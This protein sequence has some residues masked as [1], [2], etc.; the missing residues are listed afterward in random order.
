MNVTSNATAA[1]SF[2]L[3]FGLK[4]SFGFM[5]YAKAPAINLRPKESLLPEMSD[6][7]LALVAPVVA[8]WALSGIFHV[9][10]TFHLAEK[11]RIHP[12]EEVAKRNKASRMHVFLE[13]ILQHI[14][15][16]IVGLIFMHFE[17]IYM[18]G[19]EENAMWKLRADL[20]RIIPDAAIYYGY[21]YGMSALKIFAGFLF[22][23]TWQ[24][25]LHRLMH[26]NK[27]LYKWF[28][29]VHHELYVPY[30]YGA[31][32][33]N[34]VEG[35]LLDTLGTGI[36]M[37]LTHLTHR[38]QIILFTFATMKTVDDHCGYALPLDPFQWLFPNN[39]VYHDIHHQQFGIKTNFAQPFFTFW[40][41]LFQTNVK[42]FEEYQK[43][44]RRVTIDK[45]KEFLQKR[46][47]EKKEKLKNFKAMNAAENEVK[48][49]K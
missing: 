5:H 8:Y 45:Y 7:V 18:T 31:L 14:I 16:T 26:M 4:T 35:F 40:D 33:N 38:E 2:P 29:S 30:A 17:P 9:I 24:Y 6:G 19:F 20:P 34:P 44:Q 23:D 48:K 21:M 49:E 27:T 10:D 42:G 28:H 46:E 13:V 43:K 39:A 12:S 22:V 3:A 25:F 15:Q 37:T 36:A 11:Y 32:F 41:N 47:L 1:G